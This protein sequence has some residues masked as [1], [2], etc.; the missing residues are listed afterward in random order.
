MTRLAR[1]HCCEKVDA[2]TTIISLAVVK[3]LCTYPI[4]VAGCVTFTTL[5]DE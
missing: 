5:K 2:R 3:D 4:T 1:E